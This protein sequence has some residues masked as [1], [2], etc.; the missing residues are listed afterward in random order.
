MSIL[1]SSDE[2][3]FYELLNGDLEEI[4]GIDSKESYFEEL[5]LE[6]DLVPPSSVQAPTLELKDLPPHLKYAFLGE[7][8]TYPDVVSSILESMQEKKLLESLKLH[9]GQLDE[10]LPIFMA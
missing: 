9:R 5:P 6:R 2:M 8:E 10:L 7:E 1:E 4:C 3:S